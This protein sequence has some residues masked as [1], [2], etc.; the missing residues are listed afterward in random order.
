MDTTWIGVV[1]YAVAAPLTTIGV[2]ALCVIRRA[3]AA[4]RQRVVAQSR[5]VRVRVH[6]VVRVA[7]S[8]N[9]TAPVEICG[10]LRCAGCACASSR[11]IDRAEFAP[12]AGA[13]IRTGCLAALRSAPGDGFCRR[14]L[15]HKRGG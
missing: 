3:P 4:L 9:I 10:T 13:A 2:I 8:V 15:A 12:A 11:A 5:V 7:M 1:E 14:G 6:H